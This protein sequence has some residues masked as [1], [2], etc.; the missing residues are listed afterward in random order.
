M[1][2]QYNFCKGMRKFYLPSTLLNLPITLDEDIAEFV[3]K[4]AKRKQV[5]AQTVVNEILCS[6][7]EMMQARSRRPCELAH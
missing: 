1:K 6:N 3:E 5:D 2:K 7:K 4:Y